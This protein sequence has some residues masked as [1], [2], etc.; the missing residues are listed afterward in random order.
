MRVRVKTNFIFYGWTKREKGDII[1]MKP[2]DLDEWKWAVEPI[3]DQPKR[4]GRP[5]KVVE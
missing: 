5:K 1:E 2:E 4:R 3:Q